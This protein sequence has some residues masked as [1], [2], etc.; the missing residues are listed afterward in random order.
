MIFN[1]REGL[2]IPFERQ[3]HFTVNERILTTFKCFSNDVNVV[4]IRAVRCSPAFAASRVSRPALAWPYGA[5]VA[6]GRAAFAAARRLWLTV[7]AL[8]RDS[9]H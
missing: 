3:F 5:P 1:C 2:R 7:R 8:R 6:L 9:R 4:I